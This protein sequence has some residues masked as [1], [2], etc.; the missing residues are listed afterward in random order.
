MRHDA[1]APVE[2]FPDAHG[3]AREFVVDE[4]ENPWGQAVQENCDPKL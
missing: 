3:T 2:Y 4:Q 1:I